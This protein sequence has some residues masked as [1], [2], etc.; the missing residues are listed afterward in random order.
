MRLKEKY[1]KS[2]E[3]INRPKFKPKIK[4]NQ[5]KNP[6]IEKENNIKTIK[7]LQKEKDSLEKQ[8]T[9]LKTLNKILETNLHRQ[10]N[11]ET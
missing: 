3:K 9:N 2:K 11:K 7:R 1:I 6:N 5:T 4:P 8:M 10:Q